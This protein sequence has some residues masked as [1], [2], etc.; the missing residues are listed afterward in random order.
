VRAP[1]ETDRLGNPLPPRGQALR[2]FPR[3][4]LE[5]AGITLP[6]GMARDAE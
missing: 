4:L 6:P 2:Q 1:Q 3:Y 5:D